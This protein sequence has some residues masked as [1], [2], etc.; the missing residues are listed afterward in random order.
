M[1]RALRAPTNVSRLILVLCCAISFVLY[2]HRYVWGFVKQDVQREFGWDPATFGWLDGL[3]LASYGFGQIPS[4][5]LCDWFGAHVL[6]SASIISWSLALGGMALATGIASMAVARLALGLT[7]SG[8][9]PILNKVTKNWFPLSMRTTAQGWIATFFGRGG[10]AASFFVFGTVLVGW[11]HLSWRGAVG[12]FTVVGLALGVLFAFLFRNTPHEH[13]WCNEA[14]A[15]LVT[16]AD[17]EAAVATHSKLR[18]MDLARSSTAWFLFARAVVANMADLL[19]VYWFPLYLRSHM[20]LSATAAGGLA[21]LPLLG[22]ALGGLTSGAMQSRVIQRTG[23]RRW[24]RTGAGL[25]GKVTAGFL[26]LTALTTANPMVVVGLFVAVKFFAD[27]EQPAEWGATCDI[28]GRNAATVFAC[29][30]TSG[31]LGGVGGSLLNGWIL[32]HYSIDAQTTAAGWSAV[33]LLTACEF[34]VGGIFWLFV[35]SDRALVV[36][37]APKTAA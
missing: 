10:G 4:G 28:G 30:N 17:P 19:F 36:A 3:F 9:Y 35:N 27:W 25:V 16:E 5:M 29:V 23:Q 33:F 7:Q 15:E 2:L 21:A 32:N 22:G 24:A 26:T 34:A 13:P 18:W 12:V 20:K 14:E 11:L 6:L 1:N 8:V 37:S 31:Q